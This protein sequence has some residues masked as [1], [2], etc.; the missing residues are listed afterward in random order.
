[1]A[2]RSARVAR[3]V[4]RFFDVGSLVYI[5]LAGCNMRTTEYPIGAAAKELW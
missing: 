4:L 1:L 3:R 2:L 5:A